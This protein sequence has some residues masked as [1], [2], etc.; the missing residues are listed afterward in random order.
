MWFFVCLS[1]HLFI[2][3][4]LSVAAHVCI[5]SADN[6]LHGVKDKC[7]F[8]CVCVCVCVCVQALVDSDIREAM[9]V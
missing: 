5:H 9:S 8:V 2:P 3:A 4:W 1:V 7:A 6:C